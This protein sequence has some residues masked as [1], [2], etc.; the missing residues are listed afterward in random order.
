MKL[1]V[2]PLASLAIVFA[3]QLHAQ[4]AATETERRLLFSVATELE[5]LQTQLSR[6]QAAA[7][8]DARIQLDYETLSA[9][10]QE[11]RRALERHASTPSRSPRRFLPLRKSYSK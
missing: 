6:A 3:C 7:N 2:Y 4:D 9:D 8:P 11:I 5:V 1:I 10:L